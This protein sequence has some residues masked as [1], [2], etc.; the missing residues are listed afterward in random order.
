MSITGEDAGAVAEEPAPNGQAS[1]QD[2]STWLFGELRTR[3]CCL[4][5]QPGERLSEEALARE[6]S[7]SRTPLRRVI[8]RLEDAGLVRSQHGVGTIV[9]DVETEELVQIYR[10]RMELTGMMARM[11]PLL[12]DAALL[13][14]FRQIKLQCDALRTEPSAE[15]FTRT[16]R[17]F[18]DL[19][20][21]LTGNLPLREVSERLY[22]KTSRI[23]LQSV[24]TSHIELVQEIE[25]FGRE[26]G[27][28]LAALE[29]GDLTAVSHLRCAHISMSFARMRL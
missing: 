25:I 27:D 28:I 18:F 6:F 1:A 23:W 13:K 3:I 14:R 17:D 24:F 7:I 21:L 5:Y 10:L 11:D 15:K 4:V 8:A 29:L 2:R 19:L 20:Q 9:T 26:V 12:P 22:Y 16:N